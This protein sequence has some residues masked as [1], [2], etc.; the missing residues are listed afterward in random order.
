MS[1]QGWPLKRR[2]SQFVLL[3]VSM[4]LVLQVLQVQLQFLGL[5]AR[6]NSGVPSMEGLQL[7]SVG[8]EVFALHVDASV[9]D[10]VADDEASPDTSPDTA[11][12]GQA[13]SEPGPV[14]SNGSD[15]SSSSPNQTLEALPVRW[16]V[17][18][19]T[20]SAA[21]K[22]S[23]ADLKTA[24]YVSAEVLDTTAVKQAPSLSHV[25][26]SVLASL[27]TASVDINLNETLRRLS[28]YDTGRLMMLPRSHFILDQP[29][30]QVPNF[31]ANE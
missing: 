16:T 17:A 8:R 3:I 23:N 25:S 19:V 12:L 22:T 1:K 29:P 30:P 28:T 7:D 18:A 21:V 10:E 5:T 26:S 31:D 13:T 4:I 6:R 27:G 2:R 14:E 24:V 11:Q 9:S 20:L 15:S